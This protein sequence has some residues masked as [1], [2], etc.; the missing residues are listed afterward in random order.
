MKQR[1]SIS[2]NYA[3]T[4]SE[5][6]EL[7][8]LKSQDCSRY[9]W[10]IALKVLNTSLIILLIASHAILISLIARFI[11]SKSFIASVIH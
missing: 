7:F 10:I 9:T 11:Y 6:Y 8:E 3:Y 5:S 1:T 4:N 2:K